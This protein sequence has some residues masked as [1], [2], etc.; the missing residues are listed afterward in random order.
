MLLCDLVMTPRRKFIAAASL[1]VAGLAAAGF[2]LDARSARA[3]YDALVAETWRHSLADANSYRARMLDLARYATLAPSSHNTQCWKFRIQQDAV[4][5]LPDFQRRCPVVAP[6]DHHLFFSLGC[7]AENLVQAA[8]ARGFQTTAVF[9]EED[10]QSV[11]ITLEPARA[12]ASPLFEA[13]PFRQST[14][15]EFDGNVAQVPA[16]DQ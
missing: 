9:D 7:A 10:D 3:N 15:S 12:R 8:G 13:I 5:I 14:R 11:T 6:D 16:P 1:G 4:V 2:A